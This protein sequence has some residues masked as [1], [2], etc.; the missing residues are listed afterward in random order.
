MKHLLLICIFFSVTLVSCQE[1]ITEPNLL[2]DIPKVEPPF[3][4]IWI[5][6]TV[7]LPE[8]M[9]FDAKSTVC[10]QWGINYKFDPIG[11][12]P[13][14]NYEEIIHQYD[15]Q[16]EAYF[17]KLDKKFGANW[18]DSLNTEINKVLHGE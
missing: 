2:I 17:K 18:R 7:G 8:F 11:C 16:N 6:T 10:K 9:Y 3:E 12:E 4:D 15:E 5:E 14:P 1:E 13:P